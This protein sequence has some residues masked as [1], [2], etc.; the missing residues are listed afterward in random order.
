MARVHAL[1]NKHMKARSFE[2]DSSV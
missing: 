2:A 1:V